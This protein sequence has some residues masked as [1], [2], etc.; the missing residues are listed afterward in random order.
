[1][2]S[3][4]ILNERRICRRVRSHSG[5]GFLTGAGSAGGYKADAVGNSPMIKRKVLQMKKKLKSESNRHKTI[6]LQLLPF[7]KL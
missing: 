1:M 4:Q 5:N 2:D 3:G 6:S 7:E